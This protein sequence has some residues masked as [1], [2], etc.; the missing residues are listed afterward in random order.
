M[1]NNTFSGD[2]LPLRLIVLDEVDSTNDYLKTKLS[3]FKPFPEYTAIMAK[4]QTKG[5]GQRQN[6]WLAQPHVNITMSMLLLP[7]YLRISE[8]FQ[9]NMAISLALVQWLDSIGVEAEIKWPNDLLIQGKKVCGI[10][11]ENSVKG[12]AIRQSIVGI[13]INANQ[14]EFPDSIAQKAS[15][16]FRET[17]Y[18]IPNIAEACQAIQQHVRAYLEQVRTGSLS[19]TQLL[20]DYNQRLFQKNKPALYKSEGKIFEATLSHVEADG[21]LY[22]LEGQKL[23]S[24]YFKEVEFLMQ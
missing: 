15:S 20:A 7:D 21:R 22:L 17:G 5:R 16:I 1:Q 13:G 3:N 23:S 19:P 9:L 6:E 2:S 8:H 4:N 14:T 24:Y 12:A 11:I 10:L 18:L